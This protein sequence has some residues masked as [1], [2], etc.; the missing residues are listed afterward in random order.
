MSEKLLLYIDILGFSELVENHPRKIRDLYEIVASLNVHKHPAFRTIVF[1]D[2]ILVYNMDGGDSRP[3]SAYLVMFLCEFA[4]D[5]QGRLTGH[6]IVFR[7]VL[8]RGKF[9]HYEL[10]GV[11]CFYGP[12]LVSAY[13]AEKKIQAVGLFIEKPLVPDC[14]IFKTIEF[15]DQFDFVFVTQSLE[16]A[17]YHLEGRYPMDRYE[18]EETE[19]MYFLGPEII[20]LRQ[21][22]EGRAHT[23]VGVSAK[24]AKS[25][26]LFKSRYPKTTA[27]LEEA[28]FD[29]KAISSDVDWT[30]VEV[31][32]PESYAFAIKSEIHY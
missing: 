18:L 23:D 19:L 16:T 20:Y 32:Y 3:D 22:Y 21:V 9:E 10:N 27:A 8:V 29:W 26:S 4:K 11:P 2:T 28:S 7:A 24:Y 31:R 15:D 12:A 30:D 6:G 14:D 1:S 13:H 17:E 5:L 25:W